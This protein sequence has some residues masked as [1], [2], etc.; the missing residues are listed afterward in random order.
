MVGNSNTRWL[1]GPPCYTPT[2]ATLEPPVP[3][4]GLL[5]PDGTPVSYTEAAATR[6]YL[7]HS[8]DFIYYTDF[9]AASPNLQGD[10]YLN[11]TTGMDAFTAPF[12][13]PHVVAGSNAV[14][15]AAGPAG[16]EDEGGARAACIVTPHAVGHDHRSSRT[17]IPP[18]SRVA[19]TLIQSSSSHAS[20]AQS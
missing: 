15:R 1:S 14:G 9:L 8:N 13:V 7:G 12:A 19:P 6:A 4:C 20:Q 18:P 17:K 11:L 3:W 2:A 16:S 5:W 10:E